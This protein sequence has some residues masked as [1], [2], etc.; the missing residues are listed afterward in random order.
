MP[1]V[2]PSQVVALI[3]EIFP[4]AKATPRFPVYSGNAGTIAAIL[5]LVREIPDELFTISGEDYSDLVHSLEALAHAVDKWNMRGGDDP[6]SYIKGK[7]PV[8]LIR[9]AL[10]K[11]PDQSPSPGTTQLTFITDAGLRDGIRT[12]LS[13]A[14][15]ALHN[16]E[17]KASTVLAGSVVEALLLWAIQSNAPALAALAQ[18]PNGPPERWGLADLIDAAHQLQLI[19][20]NTADQARL[21]KNFRNLIHPG[22]AQRL[23]EI[24]D[25]GTALTTLAAAE[26]VIRDLTP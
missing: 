20:Q 5:R 23:Q 16:G 4:N 25:R 11:C 24:C 8:S 18:R 1:R 12:D 26:L 10:S 22:R 17:W 15:S 21:A 3:D 14:S 19:E 2:V 7:S 6:P 9:E 13:T